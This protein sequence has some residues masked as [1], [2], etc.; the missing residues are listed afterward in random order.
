[1]RTSGPDVSGKFHLRPRDASY[2]VGLTSDPGS[3][4]DVFGVGN[5]RALEP[6][7][8]IIGA[9]DATP[10]GL[11]AS[12][13]VAEWAAVAGVTV[14]SG[15]ARGCD[16][17]A[18]RAALESGGRT[19][20]VLGCGPDVVYPSNAAPLLRDITR[21][22]AV[23]S[24][25]EW[26]TPPARYRFP[27]RNRMIAALATLVVVTE[28]KVPSGTFST[29]RHAVEMGVEVA[30]VPGSIFSRFADAPNRLIADG[31][32]A[33]TRR[34]DLLTALDRLFLQEQGEEAAPGP[35]V[36]GDRCAA[37]TVE[38]RIVLALAAQPLSVPGLARALGADATAVATIVE[39]MAI[40]GRVTRFR[41]GTYMALG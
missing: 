2:P 5:P 9:R 41:D 33:I 17:A 24:P 23:V 26:G 22:G 6:G 39:R 31:A 3:S 29:V 28:A 35:D 40:D 20:A 7:V 8:A 15:A 25:F 30:A 14:Y 16:Q 38:N 19:V 32:T 11:R 12:A 4:F 37:S 27:V 18:H 21:D 10:Y 1:M 34:E 13:L 36:S